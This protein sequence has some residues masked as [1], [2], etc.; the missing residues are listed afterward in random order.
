MVAKGKAFT[1]DTHPTKR[2]VVESLTRDATVRACIF[3]LIDNSIDAARDRIFEGLSPD[4]PRDLPDSF[5]GFRVALTINGTGFKIEDNCGGIPVDALRD[6][7][8]RF[9]RVSDHQLGIGVFGVGLNRALFKLGKVSHLKTD[10]GQ[11]RAELILRTEDYLAD[12]TDWGLPAEEFASTGVVG[13]EIEIRQPTADIAQ[14]FSSEEWVRGLSDEVGRRYSRFIARAFEIKINGVASKDHEVPLREN[15]PFPIEHRYYKTANGVAVYIQCGEHADHLFKDEPGH[16]AHANRDLTPFY[17]WTVLCND[18]AIVTSDT[19]W[20]T[21]WDTKFHS[22]FYGFVGTV[23]FVAANPSILPWNTTKTDVDLGNHAYHMALEDMRKFAESWRKFQRLRLQSKKSGQPLGA[24]PPAAPAPT[25]L[26][27]PTSTQPLALAK[28]ATAKKPKTKEDHNSLRYVL[29]ADVEE[30][31]CPDKLLA[32]VHEAKLLDLGTHSYTGIVL[33]RMLFEV[34]LAT[35]LVRHGHS[36]ALDTFAKARR[37]KAVGK[38]LAA[39]HL[40]NFL[41][42][43]DEM[44]AFLEATPAVWG[45]PSHAGYLKHSLGRLAGHQGMMNGAAHAPFQTIHRSIA[46]Q[47]RDDALPIL[48]HLIET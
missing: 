24:I 40:K 14:D 34:A 3:D 9:G 26:S 11:Q 36:E 22:E 18:R 46:F 39:A 28:P 12:D 19:T 5:A 42:K 8:L 38:P 41:P 47:I 10:T 23:S 17:G 7:V 13:T 37:E 25:P 45:G 43:V 16:D 44:L 15:G 29:P 6:M 30:L 31:H 32:L 21:G 20:K 33:V 1:V 4:A 48:R 35:Y 2:V 27:P